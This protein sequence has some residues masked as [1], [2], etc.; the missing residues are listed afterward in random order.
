MVAVVRMLLVVVAGFRFVAPLAPVAERG[1][2]LCWF[3]L[4][5]FAITWT[6]NLLFGSSALPN[7]CL[8]D[9]RANLNHI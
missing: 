3:P 7:M 9:F 4:L 6:S 8:V 5:N 2:Q 1:N